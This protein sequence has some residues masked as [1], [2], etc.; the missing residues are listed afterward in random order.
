MKQI[1]KEKLFTLA[2][3]KYREFHKK[4][5]PG[6]DNIIGVKVPILRNYAKELAKN[7][8]INQLLEQ[9]DHEYYEEIMNIMKKLCCKEC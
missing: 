9:I 6:T 2:D 4:L 5:C 7:N 8:E 3:P 1:I